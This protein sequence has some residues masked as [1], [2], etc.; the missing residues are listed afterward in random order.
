MAGCSG[1]PALI[2]AS[3]RTDGNEL[4]RLIWSFNPVSG[5]IRPYRHVPVITGAMF[6]MSISARYLLRGRERG[7]GLALV[8]Y[9][10]GIRHHSHSGNPATGGQFGL[11]GRL[12]SASEAGGDGRRM[13]NRTRARA[14][15]I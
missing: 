14:V 9:Q 10:L 5:E 11:R 7:S 15:F 3:I 8:C 12:N 4:L 1:L 13:A 2:S 6:N